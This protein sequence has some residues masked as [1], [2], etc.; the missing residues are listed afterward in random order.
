MSLMIQTWSR[1]NHFFV[2]LL[3]VDP[4]VLL[5]LSRATIFI[6]PDNDCKYSKSILNLECHSSY[7]THTVISIGFE[8]PGYVFDEGDGTVS[9]GV[10]IFSTK[11]E[12]ERPV[13]VTVTVTEGTA[14]GLPLF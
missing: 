6:Q 12:L 4:S 1:W 2:N 13:S 9:I 8:Q 11:A 14:K 10:K 3:S 5:S 7:H